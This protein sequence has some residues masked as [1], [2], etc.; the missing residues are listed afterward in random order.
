M[1]D[2]QSTVDTRK[3]CF[4]HAPVPT[5]LLLWL[6]LSSVGSLLFMATYLIEGATRPGYS[7]LQHSISS[8]SLGPGGWMQQVNFVVFG[9]IIL[10]T[11]PAWR[12]LLKGGAGATWYPIFRFL[13]GFGI[14]MDGFFSQDPERGYPPGAALVAP[15]LH[16]TLH[17]VFAFIAITAIACGFFVLARRFLGDPQWRGW[18]TYTVITGILTIVCITIFGMANGQ[19]SEF[20]GLFERLATNWGTLW[21]LLFLTRLWIGTRFMVSQRQKALQ[22]A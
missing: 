21:G 1:N 13:E 15:T 7:T 11:V 14:L 12:K 10:V 22:V 9:M 6:S 19:H 5:S 2:A 17:V 3:N 16:G 8:L 20:A 18:A 4:A